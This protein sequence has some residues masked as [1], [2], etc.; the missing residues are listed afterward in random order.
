VFAASVASA[1][2]RLDYTLHCMG[3]HRAD[4]TGAP[5]E[6]PRLDDWVGYYLDVPG[7]REYL[8]QVPGARQAPVDDA[9]LAELLNW[10]LT[11]FAGGSMSGT[12]APFDAAEVTRLRNVIVDDVAA[13]RRRLEAAIRERHPQAY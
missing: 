8:V 3:C 2:P 4:G 9:A 10:M 12:F 6:I 5:P 7:G 11:Q 1:G 13:E